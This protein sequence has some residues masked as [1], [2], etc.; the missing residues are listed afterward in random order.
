[1]VFFKVRCLVLWR[2]EDG[3]AGHC[4]SRRRNLAFLPNLDGVIDKNKRTEWAMLTKAIKPISYQPFRLPSL[5]IIKTF[6]YR[7]V[8]SPVNPVNGS[9][10]QF[11]NGSLSQISFSSFLHSDSCMRNAMWICFGSWLHYGANPPWLTQVPIL[12][13]N[14]QPASTYGRCYSPIHFPCQPS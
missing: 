11:P 10:P 1:M 5:H 4:K 8:H 9:N 3:G 13:T 7:Y 14:R 12:Q 6:L 2:Q